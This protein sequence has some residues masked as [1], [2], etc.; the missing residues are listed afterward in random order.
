M[1]FA[2]LLKSFRVNEVTGDRYAGEWPRE[3]FSVHGIRYLLS[4]NPTRAKFI[5]PHSRC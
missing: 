5:K 1:E 2:E 4:E 3:R